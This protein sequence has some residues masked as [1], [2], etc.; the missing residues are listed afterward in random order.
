M[1]VGTGPS[2]GTRETYPGPYPQERMILLC[3]EELGDSRPQLCSHPAL[4]RA[5]MS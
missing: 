1:D 5:V 3:E 4:G 2:T